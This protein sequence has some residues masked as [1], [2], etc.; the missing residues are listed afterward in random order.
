VTIVAN[1]KE[2]T[3]WLEGK[4]KLFEQLAISFICERTWQGLSRA[5]SSFNVAPKKSEM[6]TA[7]A[8][9]K[10]NAKPRILLS[11]RK[12][13]RETMPGHIKFCLIEMNCMNFRNIRD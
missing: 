13:T 6:D 10:T 3:A 4:E 9:A 1:V 7:K 2:F 5:I 12:I 8:V 11:Q